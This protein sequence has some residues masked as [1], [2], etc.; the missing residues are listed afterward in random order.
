MDF[1]FLN[2]VTVDAVEA[3]KK[4]SAPR[5]KKQYQPTTADLRIWISGAIYPSDAL[6]AE[7]LLEYQDKDSEV[8]G[9]GIDIIDTREM[10]AIKTPQP[11]I[12][13]SFT[14][15]KCGKVDIFSNVGYNED[16]T[17]KVTVIEQGAATFG[18]EVLLPLL[19]EVYG[20]E[21]NVE[22]FID[23]L[24]MRDHAFTSPNGIY[25]FPKK[26]SR[27]E[28]KGEM[29]YVRRENQ[30]VFPLSFVPAEIVAEVTAVAADEATID[31][32]D[33]FADDVNAAIE[34]N[35][36]QAELFQPDGPSAAVAASTNARKS[37]ARA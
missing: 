31:N 28:K 7:F 35:T 9:N 23:L 19:K 13:L 18:K 37:S 4:V 17:P 30:T 24:V 16:S 32:N 8:Q 2:T 27:G 26:V 34:T 25:Q 29:S 33:P 1:S 5:P 22:G 36:A 10:P 3:A 21:P 15:K 14:P 20:I 12:A 11:F 6:N